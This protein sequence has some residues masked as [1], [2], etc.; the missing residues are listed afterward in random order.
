MLSHPNRRFLF[1]LLAS[2]LIL[3]ATLCGRFLYELHADNAAM[4][5][6]ILP[7]HTPPAGHA[8]VLVIAPHCDDETL[9]VGG[10][11]ADAVR[12]GA[13][14][15]VVFVTNGD[16]FPM[17]VSRQY[18]RLYPRPQ[19]YERLAHLRQAEA[20]QAMAK[21]GV[22]PTQIYFL[23]YP[24]G[25]I[26]ELWNHYWSADLPYTSRYTRCYVSP[27][28][29]S[30]RP[31]AVYCGRSLMTDLETLLRQ[32][33]PQWLY[34]PHPGDDHPDHWATY[35]FAAAALEELRQAA[36]TKPVSGSVMLSQGPAVQRDPAPTTVQVFSYLVHR[37]DWPVP[38]GLRHDAR[39]VP[40]AP[41]SDLDT[42][43]ASFALTPAC[44]A[45]KEAALLC[46]R[47]QTAVMKRFL[48]SFVRRDELFGS[49]PPVDLRYSDRGHRNFQTVISDSTAD[50]LVRRLEGSGDLTGVDAC[51]TAKSLRLRLSSRLPVSP[52][53]TYTFRIHPI[54]AS[55][56]QIE[57]L[58]LAFQHLRC[59][60]VEGR[61]LGCVLVAS[62]PLARLGGASCVLVGA[63]SRLGS[64]PI[65]RVCWRLLRLPGERRTLT[66][67]K[68][69]SPATHPA[70]RVTAGAAPA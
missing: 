9:G 69:R 5:A 22:S 67:V 44:E 35:C 48:T 65:D 7:A 68:D 50:T 31:G 38:Q 20:R 13:R 49:L 46:Y 42:C 41:L 55:G 37:G 3:G 10:L 54:G 25:G 18:R 21:L 57:P 4:Q 59:E 19:D 1:R 56:R 14:V 34:I 30:F 17:A 16:G 58:N 26:A 33:R 24:D 15:S 61:C 36:A 60:E 8:S 66:A 64:M 2:L 70:G 40:P 29:N 43:W 32:L 63:D 39:L 47:S 11:I 62:I 6:V 12:R 52:R 27:Y 23:G 53:L 28:R 51:V 45:Q